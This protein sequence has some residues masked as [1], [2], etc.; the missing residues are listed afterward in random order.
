MVVTSSVAGLG[1]VEPDRVGTEEDPFR[2]WG[3]GL[4]Y[5]DSKHEGEL[6]ALAAGA[7]LGTEVVV[8][9]PS[10]V[11]GVPGRPLPA[12]RDLHP[13][14]RQLPARS[15]ARGGGRALGLLRRARRGPRATCAPPSGAARASATCWAATTAAGWR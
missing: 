13:R 15:A 5:P 2:G 14:D 10:Y 6:E 1:P 9:N 12:R 3:M 4:V 7:R 11:L 8:T